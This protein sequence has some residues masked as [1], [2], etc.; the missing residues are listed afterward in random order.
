[1]TDAAMSIMPNERLVQELISVSNLVGCLVGQGEQ[2]TPK[3]KQAIAQ[4]QFLRKHVLLRL[5]G[6]CGMA[7]HLDATIEHIP[8]ADDI[9]EAIEAI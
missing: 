9:V 2:G 7:C 4:C 3:Y 6:M 1:M 5:R 8:H